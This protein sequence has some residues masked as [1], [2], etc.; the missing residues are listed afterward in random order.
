MA[1]KD[2]RDNRLPSHFAIELRRL[3]EQAGL[4]QQ[5]LA[6]RIGKSLAMMSHLERGRRIPNDTMVRNLGAALGVD[7]E[8][9]LELRM[10]AELSP[11]MWE[12]MEKRVTGVSRLAPTAEELFATQLRAARSGHF[13]PTDR[14]CVLAQII[15]NL[16]EISNDDLLQVRGFV[17]GMKAARSST[18]EGELAKLEEIKNS[19]RGGPRT[20]T[21]DQVTEIRARYLEGTITMQIL[22]D[23]YNIDKGTISRIINWQAR[24]SS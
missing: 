19:H 12:W 7:E 9:L 13:A 22:A 17:A 14:L 5:E 20:L 15:D 24:K 6:D 10:L 4:T 1:S 18:S 21:W 2:L 23:E 16:S 8:Q 11:S 3:R